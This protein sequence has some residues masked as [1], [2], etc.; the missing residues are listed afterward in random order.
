[1]ARLF[2]TDKERN[3]FNSLAKELIQ[4]VV[5]QKIIYYAI[6]AEH[7]NSHDVY[8]E[9]VKKSTYRPVEINARVLFKEPQQTTTQFSLDTQYS[10]EVYFHMHELQERN[11]LPK[12]GDFLKFGKVIYEINKLTRPQIV[13][14][15]IEQ[16]VMIKAECIVSRESNL[17][18]LDD[19]PGF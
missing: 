16:E 13:Y 19:I 3:L 8:N 10:I 11:I 12:E 18:V 4:K 14:G 15:Q 1:M 9:S 7:T 5:Q 2:V 17:K 6:S